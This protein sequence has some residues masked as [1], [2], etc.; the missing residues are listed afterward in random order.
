MLSEINGILEVITILIGIILLEKYVFLEPEMNPDRQKR[1]YLSG[2]ACIIAV[3]IIFGKQS[4]TGAALLAGVLNI[5]LGRKEHRLRGILLIIPLPGILNGLVV[6][7]FIIAPQLLELSEQETTLYRLFLYGILALLLLLFGAKG[8]RWRSWFRD[9]IQKRRMHRWEKILLCVAGTLMLTFSNI[10]A[11]QLVLNRQL[12]EAGNPYALDGQF[13]WD[14]GIYGIIAFVL[15]VTIIIL[16]MQGN[17]R[18]E[19]ERADAANKAKSAFVSNISHEIRTP[20]NAIVG[21]T[22]LLLRKELPAREREYLLSIQNSGN[23]LLAIVNDLLDLSK[24]EAGKMELVNEEY[25]FMPMLN[26]LAMI[27]LNRIGSKPVELL[28]D[29]DPDIPARLYGD[30]LRIRQIII[31]LMNNAVKFTEQGHICL[32]VKVAQLEQKDIKLF[33]SVKDT[34]QGIRREDL[35]RLFGA[36]QQVDERKNHHKEGTGLGLSI[37]KTLVELMNGS[38]GV[39][40]EYGKGSTFYF[41]LHQIVVNPARAADLSKGRQAVIVGNL[42]NREANALLKDLAAGYRLSY[43]QEI[44]APQPSGLPVFYF[45]DSCEALNVEKIH[46]SDVII[47]RMVN[48]MAENTLPEDALTISKPLYSYNFCSMIEARMS[49]VPENTAAISETDAEK[50]LSEYLILIVDDNEINRMI[51]AEMLSP[52]GAQID[53]AEN[54]RQAV[55]QVQQKKYDIVFMDHQMPVMDGIEAVQAI[56]AL[57]GAYYKEVPII[58]LT[59]NTEKELRKEYVQ[60][61]MSD[62]LCKPI[63]MDAIC[64]KVRKWTTG[65]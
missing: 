1:F 22:Q 37:A 27:I 51:A 12:R 61:G 32:T 24:L 62:Y 50:P 38:I 40:S 42:K 54:G 59:A 5:V 19:K 64:E 60:A 3:F 16:I 52:L 28:Y 21:M 26:D 7:F 13:A 47:C 46:A 65:K 8:K 63:D 14:I 36:F 56:R 25:D 35:E 23:A 11:R 48:P 49:A 57:E 44:T 10:A 17:L 30:A 43:A 58:A 29:I 4:A 53:T 2:I 41:T 20:M 9:N 18:E 55:Q 31:N 15:T 33:I 45:T 6:P 39:T 34:G